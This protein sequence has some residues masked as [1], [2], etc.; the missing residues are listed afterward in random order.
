[1]E[2]LY[3]ILAC[4]GMTQILVYG[5]IFN[6]VRPKQG[7]IGE[8]FNCP[9]CM[10][11]WVGLVNWFLFD[12]LQCGLISAGCISSATSSVFCMLF[13]DFGLNIKVNKE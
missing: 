6:N 11:F 4:Y 12:N 3:F 8:L 10:G 5:T 13:N 7:F 1:M 9:M 2:L